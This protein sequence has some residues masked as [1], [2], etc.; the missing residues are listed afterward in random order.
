MSTLSKINIVT[1]NVVEASDVTQLID[2][3]TNSGSYDIKINGTLGVGTSTIPSGVKLFVAGDITGSNLNVSGNITGSSLTVQ[4]VNTV[5]LNTFDRVY[6]TG[7]AQQYGYITRPN[8]TGYKGVSFACNDGSQL[9][10]V[11]A[12]SIALST[13]GQ[14]IGQTVLSYGP[15]T[16]SN[17]G[18]TAAVNLPNDG[19]KVLYGDGTWQAL[20]V[21]GFTPLTSFN[22]FTQSYYVA[23]ASFDSRINGIVIPTQDRIVSGSTSVIV[24]GDVVTV[25]GSLIGT[26]QFNV[27]GSGTFLGNITANTFTQN[28][29]RLLKDNIEPFEGNA[30]ELID[31]ISIVTYTYKSTPGEYKVGFIAEDTNEAF[32]TK[33]KNVLD[34]GNTI[35]LLLKSIQELNKRIEILEGK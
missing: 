6:L 30:T 3:F 7:M 32:S 34:A 21:T 16:A 22:P 5:N 14:L 11:F 4:N 26:T 28:S 27:S 33:N 10:S 12:D 24:T 9:D 1:G 2:A 8:V 25:S 13:S 19:S 31:T 18:T 17:I 35:G 15:I 20:S 23:S 29:S